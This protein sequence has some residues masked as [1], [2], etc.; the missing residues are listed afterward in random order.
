M[1]GVINDP[2]V[3]T[4]INEARELLGEMETALLACEQGA[5]TEETINA[6][7]RAAHTIK[8]S[9][10]LFGLDAIVAFTHVV[11]SVLD[12]VRAHEL[13]LDAPL[14]AL[15]LEC[16]DH[17]E[18]LVSAV[19]AGATH[20]PKLAAQGEALLA[21]LHTLSHA[22]PQQAAAEHE[23]ITQCGSDAWHLSV[24]FGPDVLRHGMDPLSFL[25]YLTT[26]G[27]LL[28][29]ELVDEALP[30]A[31][32]M[33]AQTC[34]VGFEIRYRSNV[35]KA[36]IE[37]AFEFVR[38][39]CQLRIVPPAAHLSEYVKLLGEMPPTDQQLGE[40]LVRC[41]SL[42]PRELDRALKAQQLAVSEHKAAPLGHILMQEGG[43]HP[44]V[45]EAALAKQREVREHKAASGAAQSEHH[46]IQVDADKL[47]K[48][49]NLVG[50]LIIAGAS[51]QLIARAAGLASL[52][53]STSRL[54]R[55]VEEI[56]DQ[57]LQL[58]MVQIGATFS[59]FQRIVRDVARE[60]GKSI[61]LETSGAETELDKTLIEQINDP[62]MHLVR[63]AI[64][65]GIE[66]A[67]TRA[68]RGKSPEG[69]LR[70][71]A[72]HDSGAVVIEV[73]D[74]GGGLDRE[75]IL[76]KARERGL[77]AE[78][79]TLTD[80]EVYA[81]IFEPGFSTADQVTSLSGRGVGMDVVRRNVAALRGSVDLD[82]RPGAGTTV[83]VRL[84]LTLAII[85]GFL[86]RVGRSALVIPLALVEECV[87][88]S[89]AEQ[90]RAGGH[91]FIDLRGEALP[92]IRLREAFSLQGVKARRESIVVVRDGGRRVGLVV[93]ELLGELQAVIKPLSK[94][95]K[96]V[97]GVGGSTILGSGEVALILD[98]A[99]LIEC[100]AIE[101]ASSPALATA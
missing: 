38:D 93:D 26:F 56:R 88:V 94:L 10:G 9:S 52:N 29:V 17:I 19:N 21:R 48:L 20:D 32:E 28:A 73:T 81:L 23:D 44:A 95:F 67:A 96:R 11:E 70:L 83:R 18:H 45:V 22:K 58:R 80:R 40:M 79:Q 89:D 84:P 98:V 101:V 31:G 41:G 27:E 42:T 59:R 68:A 15:L 57:A 64:D 16:K 5:M 61:R 87:E 77:V 100:A 24:R 62:L 35:D 55:L 76:R 43:V 4:F 74:D 82:S 12:K 37:G 8:G 39:E 60:L 1:S 33:D 53:E 50:E 25:R 36:Q 34:Y 30:P 85:D 47:E 6:L 90:S 7:F 71:N 14:A 51:T 66:D 3:A 46:S 72:Y 2:G 69:V 54:S 91:H 75:R 13:P 86:V 65:H 49:I 97:R 63:N 99:S 78:G 92:Y